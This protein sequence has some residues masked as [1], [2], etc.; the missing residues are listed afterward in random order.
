[1]LNALQAP[2]PAVPLLWYQAAQPRANPNIQPPRDQHCILKLAVGLPTTQQSIAKA[3]SLAMDQ[4]CST[5]CP[6]A[7]PQGYL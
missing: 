7:E 5:S 4:R 3:A 2:G 6:R 1:M